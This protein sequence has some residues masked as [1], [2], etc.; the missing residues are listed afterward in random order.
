ME[1]C[2]ERCPIKSLKKKK[3]GLEKKIY[4]S[5]DYVMEHIYTGL[6]AY[7]EGAIVDA[8]GTLAKI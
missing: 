4:A 1:R 8:S 5:P 2:L 7:I 3:R 6:G